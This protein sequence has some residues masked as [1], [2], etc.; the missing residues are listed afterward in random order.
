MIIKYK[1]NP[2][3][4]KVLPIIDSYYQGYIVITKDT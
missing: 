2:K 1:A 3:D 4:I